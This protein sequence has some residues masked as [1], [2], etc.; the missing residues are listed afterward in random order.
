MKTAT[1]SHAPSSRVAVRTLYNYDP[2]EVSRATGLKCTGPSLTNQ[3]SKDEADINTIVRRFG[4]T[5]V[6]P[7][8]KVMPRML[9]VDEIVDF[10]TALEQVTAAQ[11]HFLSL[12]SGIR[13]RF[14]NDPQL[15]IDFATN[16][17]NLPELRKMGLAPEASTPTPPA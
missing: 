11:D 16:P 1:A 5:G 8:P 2:N 14:H 13:E 10:R 12:P 15:F 9:E 4:L 6:L 3:A 17:H 7:A